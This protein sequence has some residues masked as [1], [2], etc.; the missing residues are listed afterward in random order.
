MMNKWLITGGA[1][2]IGSH[3]CEH[4][5]EVFPETKFVVLDKLTYAGRI[6][7]IEKLINSNK[8][9]FH[10]CDVLNGDYLEFILK[11]CNKIIHTAAE[12][13]V[14]NS[15]LN[16]TPFTATNTLGTHTL[17]QASVKCGIKEFIHVSTDEVYGENNTKNAFDENQNFAPTNPYSASKAAAEMFINAYGNA[18]GLKTKVV[19]SNN[20]YGIRQYPEKLIPSVSYKLLNGKKA[21]IQ[22]NGSNLRSFLHVKD[23]CIGMET[24]VKNGENDVYNI[25]SANEYSVIEIVERICDILGVRFNDKVDFIKDRPHNDSRYWINCDKIRS[26]DWSETKN[27]EEELPKVVNYYKTFKV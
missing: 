27:F 21:Q 25:A 20:I 7:H 19:R 24:I 26:L 10:K 5:V 23:F 22:G 1:G 17:L 15:F 4:F 14:D 12:S 6:E 13:H 16:S 9:E 3:L 2:F 11:D 8:I 18:Y